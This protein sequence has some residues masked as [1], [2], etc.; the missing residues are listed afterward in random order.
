MSAKDPD[1]LS[2]RTSSMVRAACR[3]LSSRRFAFEVAEAEA[4][5]HRAG[6]FDAVIANH[7]LYHVS[8]RRRAIEEFGEVLKPDG[9]LYAVTNGLGHMR[10]IDDLLAACGVSEA[11]VRHSRAFGLETGRDQL[12][13]SFGEVELRR[14]EDRLE[15]TDPDAI[16]AYVLSMSVA[17]LVNAD[18]LRREICAVIAR[19]GLFAVSKAT[20]MFV[21]LSPLPLQP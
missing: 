3:R 15:V 7:M 19:D 8:N 2:G 1:G 18:E 5:P 9:V 4:V 6:T 20:G 17:R 10:E 16:V 11:G 14:Y 21:A 12:R 13:S